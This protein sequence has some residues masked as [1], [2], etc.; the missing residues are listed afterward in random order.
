[1]RSS[2]ML[3]VLQSKQATHVQEPQ[4]RFFILV[5]K[6]PGTI[7]LPF[8]GDSYEQFFG[9]NPSSRARPF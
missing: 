2:S 9:T 6:S 1:M 7:Q 8:N 5:D 4:E 3:L